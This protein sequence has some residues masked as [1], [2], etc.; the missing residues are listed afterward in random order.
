M[1]DPQDLLN[2]AIG[3]ARDAGALIEQMAAN[4]IDARDKGFRD[5][6]TAADLA[7]QQFIVDYVLA[8]FPN[9]TFLAEEDDESLAAIDPDNIVWVL[10]PIDGTSNYARQ[11]PVYCVSVAASLNGEVIA[12]AIYDPKRDELF[13][14]HKG[15]GATVN[16]QPL[17]VSNTAQLSEANVL[18]DWSRAQD[19][20][21]QMADWL[22]NIAQEARTVRALGSAALVMCWIAAGR[23]DAYFN[24]FIGSWDW[25]AASLILQEAGGTI[26]N[27]QN[28]PLTIGHAKTK[29]LAT[30]GLIH[31][32]IL[33]I[34]T[35]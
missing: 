20:R 27:H 8:R 11:L 31:A 26:T 4:G 23:V 14:A 30:N 22:A 29:V 19:T 7:S 28:E 33:P 34:L 2:V 3:A 17:K 15:G 13:A 32:Q 16:G 25:A 35:R 24:Q 12:G 1:I 10:D 9:H 6:V 21:A 18:H 5:L